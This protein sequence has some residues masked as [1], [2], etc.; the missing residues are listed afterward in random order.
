MHFNTQEAEKVF[1]QYT[2]RLSNATRGLPEEMR[3]DLTTEITGHLLE[4]MSASDKTGE[5]DKLLDAIDRLGDPEKFLRPMIADYH[6]ENAVQ[7]FKPRD[8]FYAL[9]KNIGAGTAR[10][11]KFSV[12]FVLYLFLFSFAILFFGKIFLPAHT[13]LFVVN[14]QF[15]G[16]GLMFPTPGQTEVL[17]YWML[18]VSIAGFVVSYLLITLVMRLTV[19]RKS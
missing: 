8:V 4:S 12:F 1:R 11:I 13:G 15:K 6:T 9:I 19:K 10:T 7:T 18:P 17:G 5:L 2:G 16:F 14:G 3:N